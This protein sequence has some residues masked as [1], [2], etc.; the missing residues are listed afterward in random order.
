MKKNTSLAVF[1]FKLNAYCFF[2]SMHFAGRS[3]T[4]MSLSTLSVA[5][6][7][8][9]FTDGDWMC[10]LGDTLAKCKALSTL[11]LTVTN[12]DSTSIDWAMYLQYILAKTT[13]LRTLSLTFNNFD[14]LIAYGRKEKLGNFARKLSLTTMTH[15]QQLQY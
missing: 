7:H 15:N 14:R 13:S 1:S 6:G 3:V 9:S 8:Y 2:S 10:G 11:T 12:N 5:V 4:N